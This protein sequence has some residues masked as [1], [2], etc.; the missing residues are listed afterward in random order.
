MYF[1]YLIILLIDSSY[2]SDKSTKSKY[3]NISN[4]KSNNIP[5]S[6][7]AEI[8]RNN[9]FHFSEKN[10]HI[11]ISRFYQ[12]NLNKI[13]E[14]VDIELLLGYLND[15]VHCQ[16]TKSDLPKLLDECYINLF[17]I[18]QLLVEYL[19]YNESKLLS[20]L[21]EYKKRLLKVYIYNINR[22]EMN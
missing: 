20:K 8:L 22:K 11:N 9:N 2:K 14:N 5:I 12:I 6:L 4:I 13:I 21:K 10:E 18:S 1:Y 7:N 15:I 19:L 16:L 17:G 3:S